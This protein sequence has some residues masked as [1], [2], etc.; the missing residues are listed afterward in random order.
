M[1]TKKVIQRARDFINSNTGKDPIIVL[2]GPTATGKSALAIELAKAVNGYIINA[3]SR[4]VYRDMKIATAQPTPESIVDDGP[5]EKWIINDIEHHLYGF[6]S[7][8]APL[9]LFQYKK[10]VN[11]LIKYKKEKDQNKVPILVGGTGLYIDAV[12]FNF[13]LT[14]NDQSENQF[15]RDELNEMTIEQ[16]HEILG[17]D[18]KTLNESDQKN[19]HR[20]IR[21]IERKGKSFTSGSP[22]NYLYLI[23]LPEI[24]EIEENIK[25]RTNDMLAN[26]L[27]EENKALR[28][29]PAFSKLFNATIGYKEFN[30]YF[31]GK[32]TIEQTTESINLHCRQYAKRQITWFKRNAL[33]ENI[34][35]F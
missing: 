8:N 2:A 1:E 31:E 32:L 10:K 34:I 25:I 20:L 3:D 26:G 18:T 11:E 17:E 16:L 33:K 15:S 23:K 6:C 28:D 21:L 7:P 9:N 12:V 14:E 13:N 19:P 30:E 4:Q 22:L 24:N 27:V 29:N 5:H 35:V